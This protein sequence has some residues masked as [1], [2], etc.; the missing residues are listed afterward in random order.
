MIHTLPRLAMAL[1]AM[2]LLTV[3]V[4]SNVGLA[5]AEGDEDTPPQ[6]AETQIV[7]EVPDGFGELFSL[8]W[9]GG[10]F[11]HLKGRLATLGCL[12]DTIWLNDGGTW[13]VHNQ[14]QV[15]ST[16]T[17]D[18]VERYDAFVPPG[19]L[20]ATCFQLCEF[21]YLDPAT[22]YPCRTV[23]EIRRG[24]P[25]GTATS[26]SIGRIDHAVPCTDDWHPVVARDVL[27]ILP[28]LPETCILREIHPR[29][30]E[31]AGFMVA[32]FRPYW[33]VEGRVMLPK[34]A[35]LI[36][37]WGPPEYVALEAPYVALEAPRGGIRNHTQYVSKEV[38][39]L[40]HVNQFWQIAQGL[41]TDIVVWQGV[42]PN[43]HVWWDSE[44]GREFVRLSGFIRSD[45]GTY[46]LP[47][48]SV[49]R[50]VY[51]TDPLE[52]AAVLCTE[53]IID[54]LGVPSKYAWMTWDTDTKLYAMRPSYPVDFD[55]A[56]YLTPEIREW[57]ETWMVLPDIAD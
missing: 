56:K 12:V 6:L 28:L 27:P 41:R 19:T 31:I 52:L 48:N 47:P 17:H 39:E 38:H 21:E 23:D 7:A 50:D 1:V 24:I 9:G 10:S 53:Y 13:Y 32:H 46:S 14:Y 2:V 29:E 44:P 49:Y 34:N 20:W 45:D 30:P 26:L 37:V 42:G 11:L 25:P 57:I 18:F 40:C 43:R 3:A 55:T 36:A 8:Q 54:R 5:G 33:T 16:L 4:L 15:P 35:S 51:S 22:N